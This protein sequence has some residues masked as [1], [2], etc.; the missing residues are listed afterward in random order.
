[1]KK[2]YRPSPTNP[3][4]PIQI[5]TP[6]VFILESLSFEDEEKERYEGRVL[7]SIL[8]MCGK[9]PRYYYFRTEAELVELA[10]MFRAT[11]Y[12]YLHLSCHGSATDIDTT[13]ETVSIV[14]LSEIFQNILRNRRL[15]M[16]ACEVGS[17]LNSTTISSRNQGMYSIV[18]PMD[19]IRFDHAAAAW[20][21]YYVRVFELKYASM[22]H[23]DM[24]ETLI[25]ISQL[26]GIR[27]F[28]SH[29]KA[30][31]KRWEHQELPAAGLPSG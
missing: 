9:S 19:R 3:A 2:T 8:K 16:S 28:Y 6:D 1:M 15:F 31:V 13:L 14:R 27:F 21:A 11:G 26:F 30:E 23:R 25:H 24:T 7:A 20:A 5:T 4:P 18:S 17:E 10:K 29:Y 12:R 22:K